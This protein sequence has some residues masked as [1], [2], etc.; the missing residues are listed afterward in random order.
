MFNFFKTKEIIHVKLLHETELLELMNS[1]ISIHIE[2]EVDNKCSYGDLIDR[3]EEI[4]RLSVE[5]M[6]TIDYIRKQGV[7]NE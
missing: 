4:K 7:I 3:L 6:F 2:S 5:A 1:L